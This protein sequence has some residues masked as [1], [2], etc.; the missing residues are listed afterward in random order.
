MQQSKIIF[1][2]VLALCMLTNAQGQGFLKKMKQKV[3]QSADKV[4]DKKVNDATGT[5]S[6]QST[7]NNN[8]NATNASQSN[9]RTRAGNKGGEGLISTPPN[10]NENLDGAETSF[11]G[12]KYS[13]ARYAIQQAMLGVEMEIGKKI[14][15]G[16]PNTIEGLAKDS[17]QDQVT[18]TGWGWAGLTIKREYFKEDQELRFTIANNS[19]YMQA[20]NMYLTNSGYMQT[21]GGEQK[22][23]QVKVQDQKA[24]IEYDQ[25]SGYK[26]SV[27]LGQSSLLMYEGINFKNEQEF[28]KAVNNIKIETI[29][30]QLGEK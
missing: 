24:V 14:L 12:G 26:L 4:I 25:S 7:N 1:C 5:E 17:T 20:I 10:V 13:D 27:P 6:N 29:K 21:S 2:C 23:K 11:K 15:A 19:A 16:L 8:G 28:L 22:W 30:N 18:S 9:S 3:E